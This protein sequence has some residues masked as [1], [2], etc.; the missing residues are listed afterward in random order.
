M[1]DKQFILN[2]I[3]MDLFRVV[4]AVGNLH[5]A[6]PSESAGEFLTHALKDFEKTEL[7]DRELALK[8]QLKDLSTSL[9]TISDPFTRLRWTEKVLT[10]RCRL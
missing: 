7:T 4:T 9:S 3:K 2:S 6:L 1:R 8:E 5:N 10:I